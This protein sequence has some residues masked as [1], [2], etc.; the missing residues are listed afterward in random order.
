MDLC[1]VELIGFWLKHPNFP[2]MMM[3]QWIG[4]LVTGCSFLLASQ[5]WAQL[6]PSRGARKAYDEAL[7]AYRFQAYTLAET[8]IDRAL[9]KSPEYVDAWFLKA[10]LHRDLD[11]DDV[12]EVL[13]HALN[14]DGEKFPFGW[15]ELAQIQWERGQYDQALATLRTFDGLALPLTTQV[16]D[17]RQWVEAGLRFSLAARTQ[18][19]AAATLLEGQLNTDAE[20]YYGALDLTGRRMVFTRH[21]VADAEEMRLPGVAGGEDFFESFKREDGGWTSPVPLRGINTRMNEGAPALSGNGRVM[22]FAASYSSISES[23]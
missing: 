20:E 8:A 11:R 16:Q 3:R 7:E 6:A 13:Q 4:L 14:L 1:G 23:L 10:Q 5:A 22:V 2:V 9:R 19:H 18:D 21:G 15:I 17:K 12:D